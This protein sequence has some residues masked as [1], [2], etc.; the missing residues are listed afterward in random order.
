MTFITNLNKFSLLTEKEEIELAKQLNKST[1]KQYDKILS[2][3]IKHNLR[4]V[5]N[6]AY[7]YNFAV[8]D[9]EDLIQE[10]SIGLQK[11]IQKWDHTRGVR[12]GNYCYLWIRAYIIRYIMNNA[13]IVKI[14][15][16]T[17]QRKL[18]FNLA[19]IRAKY[20]SMGINI[21]DDELAKELGVKVEELKETEQRLL[22]PTVRLDASIDADKQDNNNL[23]KEII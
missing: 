5:V 7:K 14:G 2:K 21:S 3:L 19:K 4:L 13:N 10:G 16:T 9:V 22:S 15:T 17:A 18:Y 1:G 6:I 23:L 20:N 11:G 8:D 12:L